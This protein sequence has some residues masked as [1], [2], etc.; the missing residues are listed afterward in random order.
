MAET[1]SGTTCK[2]G[3]R[4]YKDFTSILDFKHV[5]VSVGNETAEKRHLTSRRQSKKATILKESFITLSSLHDELV[6][7]RCMSF[8]EAFDQGTGKVL[9]IAC[10]PDKRLDA[11]LRTRLCLK[12]VCLSFF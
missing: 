10:K 9:S 12:M 2:H 8:Q 3:K 4:P 11:T 7:V 5:S 6:A 1:S